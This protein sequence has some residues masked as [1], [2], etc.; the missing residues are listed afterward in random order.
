MSEDIVRVLRIIEYVGSRADVEQQVAKSIHGQRIIPIA[1]LSTMTITA[2]TIGEFP[3][4]MKEVPSLP[5]KLSCR[6]FNSFGGL[7]QTKEVPALELV[8]GYVLKVNYPGHES[9]KV[10]IKSIS[11]ALDR[12]PNCRNVDTEEEPSDD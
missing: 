5:E 9:F 3:E 1:G 7:I 10:I 11:L 6:I 8:A 12:G 4:I 2:A